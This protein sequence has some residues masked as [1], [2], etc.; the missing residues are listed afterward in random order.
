MT[1]ALLP[2]LLGVFLAIGIGWIAGRWRWLEHGLG[3]GHGVD[4][5]RVLSNAAFHVFVPALMFRTTARLDFATLPWRMVAAYFVPAL[6]FALAVHAWNRRSGLLP[7]AGPAVR[8]VSAT[9]GNS[10]QL[11][12]PMAAAVFGEAGLAVH[13][14]LVGLHALLLIT[15]PTVLAEAALARAQAE[16]PALAATVRATARAAV[17]HPVVLPVLAGLAWNATG[18]GLHP[19]VDET[20]LALASAVVPVC[21]VLIGLS[22]ATYGVA[23]AWRGALQTVLLKLLALPALVLVVAHWGFGLDGVPLGVLVLLAALPSGSNALIFAQRYA[24]LE[25]EATAAIVVSTLA[26][27]LTVPGWLAVLARLA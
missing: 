17:L 23:G 6:L 12:I 10:V 14:T 3:R 24:T 15:P 22:L 25:R 5:A 26:F 16:R 27:V 19:V 20:L 21:L 13:V 4:P 18:L 2:K 1:A 11:G 7:P 9:F 8:A